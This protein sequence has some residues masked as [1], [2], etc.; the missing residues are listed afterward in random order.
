MDSSSPRVLGEEA[1]LEY[2]LQN[3]KPK[4]LTLWYHMNGLDVSSLE[5]EVTTVNEVDY[6]SLLKLSGKLF[7]TMFLQVTYIVDMYGR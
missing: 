1:V 7:W 3:T 2:S 4:C 6:V 5:V